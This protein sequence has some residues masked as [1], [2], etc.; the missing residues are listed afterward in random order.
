MSAPMPPPARTDAV[1]LTVAQ[2]VVRFLT[3]QYSV[4]SAGDRA[5]RA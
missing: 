4:P 1:R 2:A 3:R 5:D